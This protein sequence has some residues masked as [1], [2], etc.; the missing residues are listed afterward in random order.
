MSC[1]KPRR[2]VPKDADFGKLRKRLLHQFQPLCAEFGKIEEHARDVAAGP[3]EAF[4]HAATD[5]V[6]LE[7][8]RDDRNCRRQRS[9]HVNGCRTSGQED[10]DVALNEIGGHW[11]NAARISPGDSR[12][13]FYLIGHTIACGLQTFGQCRYPSWRNRVRPGKEKADLRN[14]ACLLRVCRQWPRRRCA[15]ERG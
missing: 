14:F 6:G 10:V 8:Y 2:R 1:L 9:H 5:G 13:Q 15:A 12:D 7:V 4:D 11:R 3:R